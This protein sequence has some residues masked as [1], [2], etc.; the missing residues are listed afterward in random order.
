MNRL[1]RSTVVLRIIALILAC[2]LWLTV[3]AP[4]SNATNANQDGIPERFSF[5]VHVQVSPDM[6]VTT[7]DAVNAIIQV[8]SS[9]WT[10]VSLSSQMT[11]V[12]LIA[13]AQGLAPGKH[14]IPITAIG[15]PNIGSSSVSILPASLTV[16]IDKKTVTMKPVKILLQ[17]KLLKGAKIGNISVDNSMVE[18][19]GAVSSVSRVAD[20]VGSV[21][22]NGVHSLIFKTVSLKAVDMR[23]Q[24]VANVTVIPGT[25]NVTI[26][27]QTLIQRMSVLPQV[28]GQP[29]QG[30]AVSGVQLNGS[31]I[32]LYGPLST[33]LATKTITIP[34]DV[35]GMQ[36]SGEV[37]ANVPPISGVDKVSPETLV[38]HVTI[39]PSITRLFTDLPVSV[40]NLPSGMNAVIPTSS[41]V[42]VRVTGP[43]SVIN[44][45]SEQDVKVYVDGSQVN[46][47]DKTA[48][49][50]VQLPDWVSAIQVSLES[51]PIEVS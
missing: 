45:M 20:V 30:F 39:E 37:R 33:S 41:N 25:V 6:V 13:D 16:S 32:E 50:G 47:G 27:V 12:Q 29:A 11:N 4:N 34:I 24:P 28:V 44:R 5:P 31:S 23:G 7:Q 49:I 10:V 1:L 51:V 3:N 22:V 2:I 14:T 19:M 36:A 15:M 26:P 43:Q 48:K 9:M 42:S 35:T 8:K 17:G 40:I 21:S 38:A 18:V 46:R